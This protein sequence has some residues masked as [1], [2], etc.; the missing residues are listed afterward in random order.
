[1]SET[2]LAGS[3]TI[4]KRSMPIDFMSSASDFLVTIFVKSIST[5]DLPSSNANPYS[6][7]LG[8]DVAVSFETFLALALNAGFLPRI[9]PSPLEGS[10]GELPIMPCARTFEHDAIRAAIAITSRQRTGMSFMVF[11]P[12]EFCARYQM[13]RGRQTKISPSDSL[14]PRVPL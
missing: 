1:M 5:R 11:A 4:T 12:V 14:L 2:F 9:L 8:L 6:W 3:L 10:T 7:V 13:P